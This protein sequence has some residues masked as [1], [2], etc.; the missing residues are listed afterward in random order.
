[1]RNNLS[2]SSRHILIFLFHSTKVTNQ[3][4]LACKD[5]IKECTI[6]KDDVDNLWMRV[7]EEIQF[8]D[9]RDSADPQHKQ[10]RTEVISRI[11]VPLILSNLGHF[12]DHYHFIDG[13]SLKIH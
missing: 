4:V 5:H 3:L 8:R 13:G 11:K 9:Q 10:L 2:Y 6:N 1:M 12:F 7:D